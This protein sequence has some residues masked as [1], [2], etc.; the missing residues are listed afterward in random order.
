[1]LQKRANAQ[2]RDDL[3]QT[4]LHLACAAGEGETAALIIEY[5]GRMDQEDAVGQTP[6]HLAL[7]ARKDSAVRALIKRG[8][9]LPKEYADKPEMQPLIREVEKAMVEEALDE[10]KSA[11]P[12]RMKELEKAFE[13]A[14]KDLLQL[15]SIKQ[16]ARFAPVIKHCQDSLREMTE[17]ARAHAEAE[18]PLR[19][20]LEAMQQRLQDLQRLNRDAASA[21][22]AANR[23][24]K[25]GHDAV[26]QQAKQLDAV[27]AELKAKQEELRRTREQAAKVD[28]SLKDNSAKAEQLR[29]TLEES[30]EE[31]RVLREQLQQV[32]QKVD[33]IH[34]AHEKI[35]AIHN[36]ARSVAASRQRRK[37]SPGR[38][39]SRGPEVPKKRQS[40][41][42]FE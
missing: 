19:R 32:Q 9:V 20:E 28:K 12:A 11:T 37:G 2:V 42:R 30:N 27:K 29:A 6:L 15:V 13:D 16:A 31:N 21:K 26:G 40:A 1:L 10:A 38:P 7:I 39:A 5:M 14:R 8:A 24:V 3:K 33:H 36:E 23:K 25:S 34:D 35:H 17:R 18:I 22:D 41:T 4:P